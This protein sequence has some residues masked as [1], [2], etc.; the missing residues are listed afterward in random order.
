MVNEHLR[1]LHR[2]N[3]TS[4]ETIRQ[5]LL[6][7]LGVTMRS[8]NSLYPVRIIADY[9]KLHSTATIS[10]RKRKLGLKGSSATT[11]SIPDVVKRQMVL[12]Q[13]A[14]DPTGMQ[15]PRTV[16]KGIAQDT[17]ENITRYAT[18]MLSLLTGVIDL[19]SSDWIWKEM[20]ELDPDAFARRAPVKKIH[21]GPR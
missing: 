11:K 18:N 13:M 19:Y 4:K 17:G 7:D 1:V 5:L 9:Y 15:G 2:R 10:R 6:K 3:I 14:K 20:Q 21:R 16:K 12:D 8:V